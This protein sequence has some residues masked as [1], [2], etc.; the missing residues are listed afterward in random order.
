MT[1][2][3]EFPDFAE[4][5]MPAIPAGFFDTSWHNDTCP[6]FTSDQLGLTI[7]VDYADPSKR[8]YEGKYA[9]FSVSPQDHGVEC[10]GDSL[11][12]DDWSE[13]TAFVSDAIETQQSSCQHRDTGRGIC[14]D[15]GKVL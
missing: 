11:T 3:T 1:Y 14:C 13:I 5:D 4:A 2:Q 6:S 7:T 9:R 10:S 12:T 15:C 8:E